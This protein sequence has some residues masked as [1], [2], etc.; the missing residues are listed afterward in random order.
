M[1]VHCFTVVSMVWLLFSFVHTFPVLLLL[2]Y[3]DT[4]FS[5]LFLGSVALRMTNR[6]SR[7]ITTQAGI[8]SA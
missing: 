5:I 6:S 8:T 2:L 7:S 4:R 1:V 3:S